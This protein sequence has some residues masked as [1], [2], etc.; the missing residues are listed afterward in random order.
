MI[1]ANV[2]SAMGFRKRKI[3]SIIQYM[4]KAGHIPDSKEILKA[5]HPRFGDCKSL[6]EYIEY[7]IK[8]QTQ[9]F[10]ETIM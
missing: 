3:V 1:E 2:E 9:L 4:L 6:A 8:E 7:T 10:A 5:L